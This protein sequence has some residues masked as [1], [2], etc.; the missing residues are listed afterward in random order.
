MTTNVLFGT[1]IK[2]LRIS[3]NI[4]LIDLATQLG[5]DKGLLSKIENNGRRATKD[6]LEKLIQLLNADAK[7]LQTTWLATKIIY[8]LEEEEYGLEALAVAEQIVKYRA[9]KSES[10]D[11]LTEELTG[12]KI[13]LDSFRP[14]PILQLENL[15][16]TDKIDYTFESNWIEGNT[17]TLQ[18]TA[19]IVEKGLTIN[20]K[21]MREHLEAINHAEAIDFITNLVKN[22]MPFNAKTLLQLHSLILRGIDKEN[23]GRYRNIQVRIGGSTFLPPPPYLI[24][25]QI[26]DY[27]LFYEANN[28]KMHPIVLAADMHEKLATIHPFNDGNGRISRLVMNLIALQNGYPIINISGEKMNR[29]DYYNAL[30]QAQVH[31]NNKAFRLLVANYAKSS[32]NEWIKL[33]S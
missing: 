16:N 8:E 6:Q 24:E 21:S 7:L 31:N 29:M 32:L 4:K 2:S 19:M 1:L 20:G 28:N 3:K 5:M 33:C 12:L 14:I 25:K 15:S 10:L 23:A 27:F 26:E 13:E 11:K 18:E 30:E 22:K 17:L 9:L